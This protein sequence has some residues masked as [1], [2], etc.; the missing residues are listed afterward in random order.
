MF[1]ITS[2]NWKLVTCVMLHQ[3]IENCVL[4]YMVKEQPVNRAV[5][6]LCMPSAEHILMQILPFYLFDQKKKKI[7]IYQYLVILE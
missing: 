3:S 5:D 7:F 2:Y 4:F 6:Y 1:L